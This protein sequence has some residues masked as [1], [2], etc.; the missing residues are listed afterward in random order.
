MYYFLLFPSPIW[1]VFSTGYVHR[2]VLSGSDFHENRCS[3]SRA[4]FRGVPES[5]CVRAAFIF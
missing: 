4:L 2:D 1:K 3:E 5:A